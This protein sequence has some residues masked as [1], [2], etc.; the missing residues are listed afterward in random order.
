MSDPSDPS[1]PSD[2]MN[3]YS[4]DEWTV[5]SSSMIAAYGIRDHWLIVQFKN[6][7]FYRYE[8]AGADPIEVVDAMRAAESVGKYF[9]RNVKSRFRHEQ[10]TLDLPADWG[11]AA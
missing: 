5:A 6:D 10:L 8:L 9:N 7:S 11:D 4:A 2:K 3:P 1:D